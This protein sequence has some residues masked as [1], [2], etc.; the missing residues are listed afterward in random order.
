[1]KLTPSESLQITAEHQIINTTPQLLSHR[2]LAS[3]LESHPPR[4]AAFFLSAIYL[5]SLSHQHLTSD[6][7]QSPE[8]VLDYA[9][10]AL[11]NNRRKVRYH[12]DSWWITT[13][14][15]GTRW[16][17]YERIMRRPGGPSRY[18]VTPLRHARAWRWVLARKTSS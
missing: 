4:T 7:I 15:R 3:G 10:C 17:P 12:R 13:L 14:V 16:T 11:L 2:H 18:A 6:T 5:A 8:A 9:V 1:M